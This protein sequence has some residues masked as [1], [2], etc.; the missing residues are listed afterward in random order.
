[1]FYYALSLIV[2][3]AVFLVVVPALHRSIIKRLHMQDDE[4]QHILSRLV[5]ID[6]E[7][8]SILYRMRADSMDKIRAEAVDKLVKDVYKLKMEVRQKN[9]R[10]LSDKQVESWRKNH[11]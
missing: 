10:L 6:A 7:M 11:G 2:S 8:M 1:M 9:N 5:Q 4:I 3:W